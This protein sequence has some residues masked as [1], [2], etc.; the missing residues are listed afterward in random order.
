[1]QKSWNSVIAR[2][3]VAAVSL[4]PALAQAEDMIVGINLTE[5]R[6]P[7]TPGLSKR[8]PAEHM[9]FPEWVRLRRSGLLAV[10]VGSTSRSSSG[11]TRLAQ[12]KDEHLT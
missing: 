9:E 7:K 3:L 1:M 2:L 8:T 12:W 4:P 10:P 11:L 6:I 5:L